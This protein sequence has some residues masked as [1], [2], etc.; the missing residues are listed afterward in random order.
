M[1]RPPTCL[2]AHIERPTRFSPTPSLLNRFTGQKP[3]LQ[4]SSKWFHGRHDLEHGFR[5]LRQRRLVRNQL[6]QLVQQ[7]LCNRPDCVVGCVH[8]KRRRTS[9]N[10]TG[11]LFVLVE[12][13]RNCREDLLVPPSRQLSNRFR[14]RG[15]PHEKLQVPRHVACQVGLNM[16]LVTRCRLPGHLVQDHFPPTIEAPVRPRSRFEP[17]LADVTFT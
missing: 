1:L 10:H 8:L 3:P 2:R 9:P 12:C 14:L 17:R 15:C 13:I 16:G 11:D 6:H 5:H 4:L 7:S